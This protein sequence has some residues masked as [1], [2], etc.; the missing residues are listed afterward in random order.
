VLTYATVARREVA[1]RSCTTKGRGAASAPWKWASGLEARGLQALLE[2]LLLKAFD[3][4]TF[5]RRRMTGNHSHGGFADAEH[6][7]EQNLDRRVSST[8]F[9]RCRDA[10]FQRP[11][12]PPDDLVTS[13]A[14]HDF[15]V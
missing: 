2:L 4:D 1:P 7:R 9:G 10:H 8:G 11:V 15:N 5:A 14:R 3:L 13:C 6:G 12:E